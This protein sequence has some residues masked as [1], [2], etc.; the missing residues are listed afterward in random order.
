MNNRR[1]NKLFWTGLLFCAGIF[2]SAPAAPPSG[3]TWNLVWAD[4][5]NG[6]N[7]D[8]STWGY[9][10]KQWGATDNKPCLI[11]PEDT[12]L[13]HSN[14]VLRSRM[15]S[16]AGNGKTYQFSC[17]WAWSKKWLAYG[18]L[19]I[20][21]Q[22]PAGKGQWPA[23][24]MLRKGWPP[25]FDIAEF[26]GA[27]GTDSDYMTQAVY[28]EAAKWNSTTLAG[29]YTGWHTYGFE[30]GPGYLKWFI[31]GKLTK[32]V[33][34]SKVPAQPMY[35][36][37]SAGLDGTADA[38]TG[39]PNYFVIDYFRWYQVSPTNAPGAPTLHHRPSDS[40][41]VALSWNAVM[42][43]T[44]YCISR[45]TATGGP[46]TALA[47]NS[48]ISQTTYTDPSAV[49]FLNYYYVVS[50]AND[51]GS[52]PN[53]PEVMATAFPAP[54]SVG[55]PASASSY[56][57][58]H[59]PSS[60]NDGSPLSR[61]TAADS[62]YPQWWRVDLG[63]VQPLRRVVIRWENSAQWSYQYRIEVSTNDVDYTMVVDQ[64]G[65][66]ATGNTA[67]LLSASGRYVRVAVTGQDKNGWASFYECEVFGSDGP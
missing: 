1:L 66:S 7:L 52:S 53:S 28:D 17:G 29:D 42:G 40:N 44:R 26:R 59:S 61:W 33:V 11:V 19:E 22:Y 25:E 8:T 39:F 12:Y 23:W 56:E 67:D 60:A 20:R 14:L 13:E 30:W 43:A 63:S 3:Q 41:Q 36:I 2:S 35:V 47:T 46:Y 34:S 55:K 18:Y 45:A 50:A 49:N 15:G 38:S 58:E 32:T 21:A 57:S 27:R 54:I 62:G 51:F 31:D 48:G 24:W 64:T 16:F 10:Q 37:L 6:T 9:G 65:R 4:E 5:F